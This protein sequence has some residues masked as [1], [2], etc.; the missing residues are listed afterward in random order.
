M[1]KFNS[2]AAPLFGSAAL[3]LSTPALAEEPK[4]AETYRSTESWRLSTGINYS[5]GGYGELIDTKVIS[6]PVSLKYKKG[7]F[8]LR[9]SVP[10]VHVDGPGSLIETPEGS[11]GGSGRGSGGGSDNSGSGSSNS[12]SGRSGSG[13]GEIVDFGAK[14]CGDLTAAGSHFVGF[15]AIIRFDEQLVLNLNLRT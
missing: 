4:K 7:N 10:Y 1:T 6:A 12:G 11:G 15:P 3:L 9:V 2:I 14:L 8:S 13:G 5:T